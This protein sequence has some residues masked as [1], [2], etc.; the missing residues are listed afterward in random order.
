MAE[1]IGY[2][3]QIAE[4]NTNVNNTD[5]LFI[6]VDLIAESRGNTVLN[7]TSRTVTSAGDGE[8][9]LM[10]YK[11][12]NSNNKIFT[13]DYTEIYDDQGNTV[14]YEGF[15]IDNINIVVN[16]SYVPT[17][18]IKFV[19]IK[20]RSFFNKGVNSP[21]SVLTMF[22]PPIYKLKIKGYYG[23]TIE[24]KLH[25]LKYSTTFNGE[26]GNYEINCDFVGNTFAPLA[27]ILFS[28]IIEAP[29]IG[30]GDKSKKIDRGVNINTTLELITGAKRL[31]NSLAQFY[32]TDD[33][34][35]KFT[36]TKERKEQL[37][38]IVNK[39][40]TISSDRSFKFVDLYI[41][42]N[43]I[44]P[45]T[46][47]L[48]SII[49]KAQYLDT[50]Y[51]FLLIRKT[52]AQIF[53]NNDYIGFLSN[54]LFTT[55]AYNTFIR[56]KINL[57][58][59]TIFQNGIIKEV[60]NLSSLF[61][62]LNKI[63]T[64]EHNIL[65]AL[66]EKIKLKINDITFGTLGFTP[67]IFNVFKVICGDID[68]LFNKLSKTYNDSLDVLNV[69][70]SPLR[71]DIINSNRSFNGKRIETLYPFPDIIQENKKTYPEVLG[72]NFNTM[73]EVKFVNDFIASFINTK[74][75]KE[76]ENVRTD[77]DQFGSKKWIPN[78]FYDTNDGAFNSE[79]PYIDL[80]TPEEIIFQ[81]LDRYLVFTNYTYGE[82]IIFKQFIT[83]NPPTNVSSNYEFNQ[84]M[85]EFITKSEGVNLINSLNNSKL[86]NTFLSVLGEL[87]ENNLSN[88][89][90]NYDALI[91]PNNEIYFNW[92]NFRGLDIRER[93]ND[94]T[95]LNASDSES[96]ESIN[97]LIEQLVGK[98]IFTP[99]NENFNGELKIIDVDD[100]GF[101][102]DKNNLF[103]FHDGNDNNHSYFIG[104]GFFQFLT[105]K[106]TISEEI[107][108]NVGIFSTP[109]NFLGTNNIVDVIE[110]IYKSSLI[111]EADKKFYLT[112][113]LFHQ[114]LDKLKIIG[115]FVG[116]ISIP[117]FRLMQLSSL[118]FGNSITKINN[119][120]DYIENN[121]SG[122]R[123]QDVLDS[124]VFDLRGLH[125]FFEDVST[126]DKES[127]KS[128]YT[129]N[130]DEYYDNFE[131]LLLR[132]NVTNI[133]AG[134]NYLESS[135]FKTI[136]NT[137]IGI[138]Q[139]LII[140][141]IYFI[142]GGEK[143]DK[144]KISDGKS[145]ILNDSVKSASFLKAVYNNIE[146]VLLE[147][148]NSKQKE[149]N[150]INSTAVDNNV[151][152]E[153]YYSF[154][155]LVDRWLTSTLNNSNK[156]KENSNYGIVEDNT[157][158]LI[159]YFSFVDRVGKDIGKENVIDVS[160]LGQFENDYDVNVL[161]VFSKLLGDNGYEFYPLQNFIDFNENPNSNEA[162]L[163][164][165]FNLTTQSDE[166]VRSPR[167]TCLYV[168]NPSNFVNDNEGGYYLDDGVDFNNPTK[169]PRD[170]S[171][172]KQPVNIFRVAFGENKQSIF[173]GIEMNTEEHQPTNES[174]KVLSQILDGN[175][176]EASPLNI[177]QNLFSV[178][179]QRSYTCKIT[180]LG[181]AMIQPTQFF[182]LENVPLF[183]GGYIILN[184]EHNIDNSNHM[185]TTF[186]GV[187]ISI[188][189]KILITDPYSKIHGNSYF[190]CNDADDEIYDST[191]K[192]ISDN[193]VNANEM[194]EGVKIAP[195]RPIS[196]YLNYK[197]VIITNSGLDNELYD[198][199]FFGGV[200][201]DRENVISN[202]KHSAKLYDRIH[203]F[204]NGKILLNS[205]FRSEVLNSSLEGASP[206]SNHLVGYAF[207]FELNGE[208]TTE[209]G[210]A[211]LNTTRDLYNYLR[212]TLDV[213]DY[214]ELYYESRKREVGVSIWIHIA[215]KQS[216][217]RGMFRDI[218]A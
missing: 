206:T 4:P 179:E 57:K 212:R 173:S 15:G 106:R 2:Q 188:H 17:V 207:D 38:L 93:P 91:P 147:K 183:R 64:D 126:I 195:N 107:A 27:D 100:F 18:K 73:P 122:N 54:D 114:N 109:N 69:S 33:N 31:N 132:L 76:I 42:N 204:T 77:T 41:R 217:N 24:Y 160:V 148:A 47:K 128:Y 53:D 45:P 68:I 112:H 143:N 60:L 82:E 180:M 167:F 216:G 103:Y 159:N 185:T 30:E 16:A 85:F 99:P 170:I 163:Q 131:E 102:I 151:K 86:I 46:P 177:S 149:L 8:V 26:S 198:P 153:I 213:S 120:A 209:D 141:S 214:D 104:E 11:V 200:A 192:T 154:K 87:N 58:Y 135:E 140:N 218:I 117:K 202:I 29:Y 84:S 190:N 95:I 158:E 35:V 61:R 201:T 136:I 138:K 56:D 13:T 52:G 125:E 48:T 203:D 139:N 28:Y 98:K 96:N 70:G 124:I 101:T 199:M 168:G 175:V 40:Y 157:T 189:E 211:Q 150:D 111:T 129:A 208:T 3:I 152:N 186:T 210:T 162:P 121:F 110:S 155:V 10:G 89:L 97:K 44:A 6:Y 137:K 80:Y 55:Y 67:T 174:L 176:N 171:N 32:K 156:L 74:A 187:R 51:D 20:G 146:T 14:T 79:S 166:P 75:R 37:K 215:S 5:E 194:Y 142:N 178:L 123:L 9:N 72:G 169:I 119:L 115:S 63:Y 144:F 116:N 50:N 145:Y 1:N 130:I 191:I 59:E 7:T 36:A 71:A 134:V 39:S 113:L 78:N 127:F 184:V 12:D 172:S 66:S 65:C 23:S 83:A 22:P 105:G 49:T 108:K 118:F 43:I 181:N 196:K 90:S 133:S 88:Y 161:S 205:Y 34:V 21:Y 92:D 182:Q 165:M 94:Y 81:I 164:K 19:D 197:N 25:L 62:D 193:K